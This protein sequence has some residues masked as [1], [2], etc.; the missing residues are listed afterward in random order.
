LRLKRAGGL[1]TTEPAGNRG[2]ELVT[3]WTGVRASV[4]H[5]VLMGRNQKARVQEKVLM[6]E[7]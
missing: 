3:G 6:G 1:R 7:R 5:R 4:V 2:H